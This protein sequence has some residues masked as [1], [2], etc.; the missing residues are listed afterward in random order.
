MPNAILVNTEYQHQ[1][2]KTEERKK[3]W[4]NE[5]IVRGTKSEE[6][7]R[8]PGINSIKNNEL[9]KMATEKK[10]ANN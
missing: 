4:K 9:F 8:E 6:I 10:M 7:E 2:P 3:N 5:R 1:I